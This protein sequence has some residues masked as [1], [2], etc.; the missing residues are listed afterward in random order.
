MGKLIRFDYAKKGKQD[1]KMCREQIKLIVN[2]HTVQ[3]RSKN[4]Y[5]V[6]D[7]IQIAEEILAVYMDKPFGATPIFQVIRDFDFEVCNSDLN[8]FDEGGIS[9]IIKVNGNTKDFYGT[10]KIII[11]NMNDPISHQRFVAAH[12]LGHYIMDCLGDSKYLDPNILFEEKYKYNSHQDKKEKCAD[13]FAA[14]LLMPTKK[15]VYRYN[16]ASKAYFGNKKK[17]VEY[18]ADYFQVKPKSIE[19]RVKEILLE[20]CAE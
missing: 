2:K 14:E 5:Y 9:G 19:K 16:V 1:K 20:R 17:I 4:E 7:A 13:Q 11:T 3:K 10:D 12:E 8:N 18:L 15:F 6:A